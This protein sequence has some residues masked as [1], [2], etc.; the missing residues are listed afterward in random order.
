[1][2]CRRCGVLGQ[3]DAEANVCLVCIDDGYDPDTGEWNQ[4]PDEEEDEADE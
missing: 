3:W 2:S 4:Q 1:M